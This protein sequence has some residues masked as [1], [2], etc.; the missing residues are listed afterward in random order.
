MM[1]TNKTPKLTR[2]YEKMEKKESQQGDSNPRPTDYESVAKGTVK[3]LKT[4]VDY[5]FCRNNVLFLFI[6][7]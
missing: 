1:D 4:N 2:Q 5:C 7:I 6:S 3:L